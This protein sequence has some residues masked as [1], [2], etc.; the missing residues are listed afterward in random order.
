MPHVQTQ[1]MYSCRAAV[2]AALLAGLM[3]SDTR[4]SNLAGRML[5]PIFGLISH[6]SSTGAGGALRCAGRLAASPAGWRSFQARR[7]TFR[8]RA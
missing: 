3:L 1:L 8:C 7:P 2:L 6:N 4:V 5:I